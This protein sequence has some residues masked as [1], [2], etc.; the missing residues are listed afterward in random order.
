MN[1]NLHDFFGSIW[2]M[3]FD[4]FVL[5]FE[6]LDAIWHCGLSCLC[7]VKEVDNLAIRESLFNILITEINY[8]ISISKSFSTYTIAENN[9]FFTIEINSLNFS[10]WVLNFVFDRDIFVILIMIHNIH[11]NIILF[12]N[13][14][15][16][17]G[18]FLSLL[19]GKGNLCS[20]DF[21]LVSVTFGRAFFSDL[22]FYLFKILSCWFESRQYIPLH[23][24]LANLPHILVTSGTCSSSNTSGTLLSWN[25]SGSVGVWICLRS[26]LIFN[27]SEFFV[28]VV[29]ILRTLT[30]ILEILKWFDLF[31]DLFVNCLDFMLSW[32][33]VGVSLRSVFILHWFDTAADLS[34]VSATLIVFNDCA[35]CSGSTSC[36]FTSVMYIL[37]GIK[38][39]SNIILILLCS[40]TIQ[41][42]LSLV[43]RCVNF[44]HRAVLTL[45]FL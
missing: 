27:I 1:I 12:P 26:N 43:V 39:I 41:L 19:F 10:V 17:L 31:L 23:S 5:E 42:V 45:D 13:R 30:W 33:T 20:F 15:Q 21:W 2:E 38:L 6:D 29:Q 8:G 18:F 22:L 32:E 36:T 4:L 7:L 37:K 9:F 40:I 35:W 3:L 16:I 11:L 28:C 34:F 44:L 25:S 24:I 14:S